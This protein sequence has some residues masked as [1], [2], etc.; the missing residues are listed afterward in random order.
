MTTPRCERLSLDELTDYAAGELPDADAAAVEA[1]LFSCADCAA[2][3][4]EFDGLATA[5]ADTARA[6]GI[7]GL[8]T[9]D[10]L[11]QLARDG[12]RVRSYSL[13]P[14]DVVA[15]AVWDDD[16]VMALRLRADFTGV[17]TVR[18]TRRAGDQDVGDLRGDIPHGVNEII[19]VDPAALIREVPAGRVALTLSACEG[20]GERILGTYTL[21]HEGRLGRRS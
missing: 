7:G 12:L 19:V 8:L 9:D 20:D 3:A 21:L 11:N 6:A 4:A 2:R 18:V 10:V 1:H 13:S 15:C 14:G 5:I 17:T 16:E